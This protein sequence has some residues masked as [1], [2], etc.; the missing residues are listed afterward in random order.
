MSLFRRKSQQPTP[1][2]INR[3]IAGPPLFIPPHNPG[4][5]WGKALGIVFAVLIPAA[6]VVY[7]NTLAFPD[8]SLLASG[9]VVVTCGIA[10]I[11][12]IASGKA[13]RTTARYCLLAGIVLSAV[14]SANLVGHWVLARELSAAK[15]ATT[16]RHTEEDREETRRE[17]DANRQKT[18][19]EAQTKALRAEAWR[20]AEARRLGMRAPRGASV[21]APTSTTVTQPTA[22]PVTDQ[23]ETPKQMTVEEVMKKWSWWLLWLAVADLASSVVAFGICAALWEW[24]KNGN[25]IPDHLEQY[26]MWQQYQQYMAQQPARQDAQNPFPH[27]LGK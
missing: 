17:A 2:V 14:L 5:G 27:E 10:V 3:P 22:P 21:S 6:L 18:L 8:S 15:Q 26:L 13:T 4:F 20:N 1:P 7:A 11:F 12:A 19:L 25:G 9:M 23:S 16:A 24:D